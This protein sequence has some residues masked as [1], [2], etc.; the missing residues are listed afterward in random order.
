[1]GQAASIYKLRL[2]KRPKAVSFRSSPACTT[3]ACEH[4]HPVHYWHDPQG[5]GRSLAAL[6]KP[7]ANESCA[8]SFPNFLSAH[9]FVMKDPY[10][11]YLSLEIW[12]LS[13][14]STRVH[15]TSRS[16]TN[17]SVQIQL[18]SFH[19]PRGLAKHRPE[20]SRRPRVFLSN[21]WSRNRN[22]CSINIGNV[23]STRSWSWSTFF[24]FQRSEEKRNFVKITAAAAAWTI[25][26]RW[27]TENSNNQARENNLRNSKA[28]KVCTTNSIKRWQ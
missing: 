28:D 6:S 24:V 9:S 16:R 1:M 4:M 14:K 20:C 26:K 3:V 23:S 10:V 5:S 21:S 17:C 2:R 11:I 25:N 8:P 22:G 7:V 19:H 12:D 18:T 13:Y 27:S 15:M